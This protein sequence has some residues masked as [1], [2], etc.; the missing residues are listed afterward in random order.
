MRLLAPQDMTTDQ[1]LT[2]SLKQS[3]TE[4]WR[5]AKD[6]VIDTILLSRHQGSLP[7][8]FY[9]RV[10][11]VGDQLN[12][13]LLSLI[14]KKQTVEV[15]SPLTPHVLAIG[16]IVHLAGRGSYLWGCGMIDKDLPLP[17]RRISQSRIRALRGRLTQDQFIRKG[18]NFKHLPLGDPAVLVSKYYTAKADGNTYKVGLIPHYSHYQTISAQLGSHDSIKLIDVRSTPQQFIE[19]LTSCSFILSSSLHGLIF[20]DTFE[21]P[22]KWIKLNQSLFGGD[23]KFHDYYTTTDCSDEKPEYH[24]PSIR[25]IDNFCKS[26]VRETSVKRFILSK[27]SLLDSFPYSL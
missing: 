9:S 6:R 19:D 11:N 4:R 12:T 27:E 16:S 10:F 25:S 1:S 26:L 15:T 18:Y 2:S 8:R 21:I 5:N 7:I 17:W 14:S 24:D 20:A 23:F 13:E 3:F 22:N